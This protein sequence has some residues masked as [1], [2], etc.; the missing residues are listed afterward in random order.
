[1]SEIEIQT[2]EKPVFKRV[3]VDV[4]DVLPAIHEAYR[5]P[6]SEI[7]PPEGSQAGPDIGSFLPQ[8]QRPEFHDKVIDKINGTPDVDMVNQAHEQGGA[9]DAVRPVSD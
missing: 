8:M 6:L 3:G 7:I 4:G 1:M 5:R 2:T 9:G